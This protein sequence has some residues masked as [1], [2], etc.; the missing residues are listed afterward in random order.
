MM[1]A[2]DCEDSAMRSWKDLVK[3]NGSFYC[4]LS[5]RNA[6]PE[7]E[8][9]PLTKTL[10]ATEHSAFHPHSDWL[11]KNE[12]IY[13]NSHP[14]ASVRLSNG[15]NRTILRIGDDMLRQPVEPIDGES[16][17]FGPPSAPSCHTIKLVIGEPLSL[18]TSEYV[19]WDGSQ[20]GAQSAASAEGDD[21]VGQ[22]DDDDDDD[23][24]SDQI[25]LQ[26]DGL[27]PLSPTSSF[28]RQS[29]VDDELTHSCC[30]FFDQRQQ[31]LSSFVSTS[32]NP[33][34]TSTPEAA[35]SAADSAAKSPVPGLNA[36]M[37]HLRMEIVSLVNQDDA[38]FRQLLALNTSIH[39]LRSQSLQRRARTLS[40][41]RSRGQLSPML[42]ASLTSL[43]S[44]TSLSDGEDVEV[45]GDDS[46]PDPKNAKAVG[47]SSADRQICPVT[48][49]T[50]KPVAPQQLT[51]TRKRVSYPPKS[52]NRSNS[53]L[54]RCSFNSS[55]SSS[56][57]SSSTSSGSPTWSLSSADAK[58][59]VKGV[60]TPRSPHSSFYSRSSTKHPQLSTKQR[61]TSKHDDLLMV[62]HK[63]QG[64]YDSGCQGSEP[65]DAEVFV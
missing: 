8:P 36:K 11:T 28:R 55:S 15:T 20:I 47:T 17:E 60:K 38:L 40:S 43:I 12:P 54:S 35:N 5:L 52:R 9:L 39:Q 23:S 10:D 21:D 48:V 58:A 29:I 25:H 6:E 7:L 57:S 49:T 61:S 45:E 19:S 56:S 27:P 22:N 65:S 64:S 4:N 24:G 42:S 1:T 63:R 14:N 44:L 51:L 13:V 18:D 3:V 50:P 33:T 46:D 2:N 53:Q 41:S 34:S 26:V 37:E 30:R 62:F 31:K 59:I 16:K 32:W